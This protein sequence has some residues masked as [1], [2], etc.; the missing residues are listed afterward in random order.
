MHQSQGMSKFVQDGTLLVGIHSRRVCINPTKVHRRLCLSDGLVLSTNIGPRSL[1]FVETDTNLGFL[2]VVVALE[3]EVHVAFPFLDGIVHFLL[4]HIIT[5]EVTISQ[6][7]NIFNLFQY[8]HY[9]RPERE[10]VVSPNSGAIR[11]FV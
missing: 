10:H 8:S 5:V 11:E 3:L 4:L 9:N 6:D 7:L 2:G 1:P